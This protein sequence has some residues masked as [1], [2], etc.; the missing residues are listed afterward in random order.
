MTFIYSWF[1]ILCQFNRI[2]FLSSRFKT[3]RHQKM[4]SLKSICSFQCLKWHLMRPAVTLLLIIPNSFFFLLSNYSQH[5]ILLYWFQ[6]CSI[7]IRHL[8]TLQRPWLYV[9]N[10][11]FGF[12]GKWKHLPLQSFIQ[13]WCFLLCSSKF[14]EDFLKTFLISCIWEVL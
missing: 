12:T 8:Y 11:G 13:M 14:C 5:S 3:S 6:V 1:G 10:F 9:Y 7:V 4:N 2:I